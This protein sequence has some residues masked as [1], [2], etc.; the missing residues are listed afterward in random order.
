[1]SIA[2]AR[3]ETHRARERAV[4]QVLGRIPDPEIP[5]LTLADLGIV[6]AVR[7]DAQGRLRVSITPTYTGCPA[8]QAIREAVRAEL[9]AQGW[10]DALLE[11][12]LAPPWSSEWISAEGHRKLLEFGIAPPVAS[13]QPIVCPRCASSDTRCVS[14]FGSTPCKAHYQC[15]ACSEPFDHFK[16]L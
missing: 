7:H 5:V 2:L 13:A 4:L 12:V 9:D 8:T 10:P 15:R 1:M 14:Q 3:D 16:C 6:R 11:E